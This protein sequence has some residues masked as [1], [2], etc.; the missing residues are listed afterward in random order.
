MPTEDEL[1]DAQIKLYQRQIR[2][3]TPKA[4][5]MI[6]LAVA[7]LA[8]TSHLVDWLSSPRT[9]TINVHLDAPLRLP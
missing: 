4:L 1:R 7:A 6:L 3:E 9:Q 5:A 8:A 2:W